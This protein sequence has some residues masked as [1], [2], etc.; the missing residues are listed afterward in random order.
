M[1]R[2]SSS[3]TENDAVRIGRIPIFVA[4]FVLIPI[5]QSGNQ[6]RQ[7]RSMYE[8]EINTFNCTYKSVFEPPLLV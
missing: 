3:S 2:L 4:R 6:Q 7:A 5:T 8:G 1:A